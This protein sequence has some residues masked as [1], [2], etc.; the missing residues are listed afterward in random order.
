M[1][2]D[3][4]EAAVML[5]EAVKNTDICFDYTIIIDSGLHRFG[6]KPEKA[7]ML[8]KELKELKNLNFIG[9]STH[10]GQV[11]G[12]S[13]IDEVKKTAEEEVSCLKIAKES[14]EKEGFKVRITA[15]GSTPTAIFA[16]QAGI[17]NILRPGNYVFYDNIQKALGVANEDNCSLLYL[18]L[19]FPIRKRTYI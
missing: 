3:G 5:Q 8:A 16:I 6:V 17:I 12:N 1:S 7:W 2:F 9:I 18:E 10:P 4:K 14:I 15:S 11:Y 13:N 19:L